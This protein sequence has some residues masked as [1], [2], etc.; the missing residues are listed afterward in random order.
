MQLK[1]KEATKIELPCHKII[2]TLNRIENSKLYKNDFIIIIFI[3]FSL[4]LGQQIN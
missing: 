4:D 2:K 3:Q 1:K